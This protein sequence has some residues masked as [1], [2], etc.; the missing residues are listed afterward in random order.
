MIVS[1]R[2]YILVLARGLKDAGYQVVLTTAARFETFAT[3]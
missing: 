1:I 2:I 3:A